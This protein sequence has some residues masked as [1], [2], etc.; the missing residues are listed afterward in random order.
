MTSLVVEH[1][2]APGSTRD[3]RAF[4]AA[5]DRAGDVLAGRTVWC[6]ATRPAGGGPAQDLRTQIEGAGPELAAENL[7]VPQGGDQLHQLAE[8]IDEMLTGLAAR[9]VLGRS[10]RGI[11]AEAARMAEEL[12]GDWLRPDDVLV[13]H[14]AY[15]ALL[16]PAVRARGAHAVWRFRI[17][18]P[19]EASPPGALDFIGRFTA[20]IDAY[21]LSWIERRPGGEVVERV[22][23]A[24]P[25][26][27]IVAAKEF[28]TRSERDEPR[29]LAWRMA[30]AEVVR[31]D[32]GEV[33]GG[34]LHPRPTIAAH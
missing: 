34:T 16:S 21:L 15:S 5:G 19:S 9:P 4:G 2:D 8:R 26:A 10:E 18:F 28:P 29:R 3:T 20:G 30:M 32:R 24:I 25:S 17:G 11:Y 13:A 14:D 23:A 6:A 1:F 27:G 12:V 31:A 22:A 7:E 33:V